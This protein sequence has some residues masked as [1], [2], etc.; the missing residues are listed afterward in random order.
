MRGTRSSTQALGRIPLDAREDGFDLA[1]FSGHKIHGP[2]GAGALYV[3]GGIDALPPGSLPAEAREDILRG[4]TANVPALAGF[5]EACRLARER[6][7]VD[8]ARIRRLR[9]RLEDA[10]RERFPEVRVNGD[11]GMRLPNT[12]NLVFPGADARILLRALHEVAAS[13]RSACS[14]GSAEPSHVLKAMGLSDE[15]AFASVRF[16]L[17]RFTTEDE[18]E[19]AIPLIA[20]AYAKLDPAS[21]RP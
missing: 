14:S 8:M 21:R 1:A 19:R 3:R 15:D 17:G 20:A 13:T 9:D 18:I 5:G 12:A 11:R 6:M 7:A 4:G 16:S 10:L 2:K